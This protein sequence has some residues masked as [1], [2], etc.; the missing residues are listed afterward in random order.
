MKSH[1][2]S[3]IVHGHYPQDFL[4][5]SISNVYNLSTHSLANQRSG[6]NILLSCIARVPF[7]PHIIVFPEISWKQPNR[8]DFDS[9]AH[10]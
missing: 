9:H 4:L 5:L 8:T 7:H 10:V 1:I 6:K 2:Q 3:C